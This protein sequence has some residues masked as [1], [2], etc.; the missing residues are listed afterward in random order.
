MLI[1]VSI[2]EISVKTVVT[3]SSVF[4]RLSCFISKGEKN[5]L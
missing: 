1:E 5:S 3:L 2:K 4:L